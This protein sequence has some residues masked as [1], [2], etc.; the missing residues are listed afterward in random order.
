MNKNWKAFIALQIALLVSSLGGVCSKMAGRQE[1]MSWPFLMFYGMLLLILFAYAIVWQ[2]VLKKIS[3]T[4]AYACKGI[5]IIYGIIWGVLFFHE[6]IKWNMI[7]GAFLVLIGVY[8]YI[9][10]EV[11]EEKNDNTYSDIS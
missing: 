6:T 3:L 7:L 5:G 1:F 8:C 4:V 11:K 9:A 2:Q 10:D